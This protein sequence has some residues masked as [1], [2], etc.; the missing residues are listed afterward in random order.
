MLKNGEIQG[1][2]SEFRGET[3]YETVLKRNYDFLKAWFRDGI[4]T[5]TS[6]DYLWDR[7]KEKGLR[8]NNPAHLLD[9]IKDL[10]KAIKDIEDKH[11]KIKK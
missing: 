1:V 10:K 3:I 4:V 8:A 5:N 2:K 7:S 6:M 11:K 9:K